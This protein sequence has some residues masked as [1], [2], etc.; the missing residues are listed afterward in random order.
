MLA[1]ISEF[2]KL[3]QEVSIPAVDNYRLA[4]F[5]VLKFDETNWRY[6][7]L[8]GIGNGQRHKIMSLVG[9]GEYLF[10]IIVQKVRNQKDG[11]EPFQCLDS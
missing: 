8:P 2:F 3:Y 9:D 11:S 5:S 4:C 7:L 10:I 6:R 1:S